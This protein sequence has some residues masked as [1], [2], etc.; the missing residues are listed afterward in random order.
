MLASTPTYKY[1]HMHRKE[2]E[3]Q[4]QIQGGVLRVLKHPP[5]GKV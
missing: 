5:L 1:M 2:G 3:G 4:G